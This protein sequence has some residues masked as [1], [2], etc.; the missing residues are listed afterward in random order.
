MSAATH[1]D[2]E[3]RPPAQRSRR[4]INAVVTTLYSFDEANFYDV[5]YIN[6]G[7]S[8]FASP[9]DAATGFMVNQSEQRTSTYIPPEVWNQLP[10]SDT[11]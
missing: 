10:K 5:G 8:Y 9:D 7:D 3:I 4:T 11:S 6:G 2:A 1:H